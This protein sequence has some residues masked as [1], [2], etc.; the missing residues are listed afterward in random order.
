MM[1]HMIWVE[2]PSVNRLGGCCGLQPS[3]HRARGLGSGSIF[4]G[5]LGCIELL[6]VLTPVWLQRTR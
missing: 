2:A 5:Y 6:S 1:E 4:E 3:S